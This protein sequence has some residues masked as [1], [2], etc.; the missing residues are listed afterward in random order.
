MNLKPI[1]HKNITIRFVVRSVKQA[2][3][4]LER[5]RMGMESLMD[6]VIF[7]YA[8]IQKTDAQNAATN[9]GETTA[10]GYVSPR[11]TIHGYRCSA[12]NAAQ[13]WLSG[14]E[15]VDHSGDAPIFAGTTKVL[16]DIQKR[17]F[18]HRLQYKNF[19]SINFC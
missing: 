19:L 13:I 8:I 17:T 9:G 18:P 1:W 6:A 12:Q 15:V 11:P 4:L 14:K 10:A 2:Y 5:E 3:W 16:A 7:P